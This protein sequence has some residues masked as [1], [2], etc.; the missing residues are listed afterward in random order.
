MA[1][2][3]ITLRFCRYA[4]V[5]IDKATLTVTQAAFS[6][7][8]RIKDETGGTHFQ[9]FVDCAQGDSPESAQE[10]LERKLK[11]RDWLKVFAK[12]IRPEHRLASPAAFTRRR[13]A[14]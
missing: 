13:G 2:E 8:P 7:R 1:G 6:D 10:E 12:F 9:L 5:A 11:Q 14:P 4:L 3:S